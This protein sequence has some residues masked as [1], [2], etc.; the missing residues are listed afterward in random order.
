MDVDYLVLGTPCN[1]FSTMRPKRFSSGSVKNHQLTK[2]TFED[3]L[4]LLQMFEP[5]TCT[6]EQTEGFDQCEE[7]GSTTT[8]LDRHNFGCL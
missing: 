8:P 1:P 2:H 3:A 6:M 5:P 7:S 4:D